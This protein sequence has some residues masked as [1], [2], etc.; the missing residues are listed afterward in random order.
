[1]A[2]SGGR[3]LAAEV[4][5]VTGWPARGCLPAAS[6]EPDNSVCCMLV[7]VLLV[8][9]GVERRVCVFAGSDTLVG[10]LGEG[11]IVTCLP[12]E[13]VGITATWEEGTPRVEVG[14]TVT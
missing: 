8:V 10:C 1:M 14:I 11:T 12:C 6:L 4:A 13:E 3:L 5:E 7:L 9:D 2:E